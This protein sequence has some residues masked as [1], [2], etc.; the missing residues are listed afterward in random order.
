MGRCRRRPRAEED[1]GF[2][3]IG[4]RKADPYA[5]FDGIEMSTRRTGAIQLARLMDL[6]LSVQLLPPLRDVDEPADGAS[7]KP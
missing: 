4:L 5:V 7:G 3:A 2:W 1:G 6:N